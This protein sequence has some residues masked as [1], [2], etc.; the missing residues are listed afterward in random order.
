MESTTHK[1]N[2][3][4]TCSVNSLVLFLDSGSIDSVRAALL[5]FSHVLQLA[6]HG[7]GS[8]ST[9]IQMHQKCIPFS[10]LVNWGSESL[11]L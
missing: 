1:P 3:K 10:A 4:S 7:K 5:I 9:N 11:F 6:A 2:C 8:L